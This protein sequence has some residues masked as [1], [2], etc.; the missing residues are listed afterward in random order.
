MKIM[1]L[2][3]GAKTVGVAVSDELLLMAHPVETIK[4]ENENKLRKT[5]ARIEALIKEHDVGKI[6]LGLPLMLDDSVGERAQKTIEFKEKLEKRTGLPVV[7]VDERFTT[8]ASE[9]ELD[10]MDVPR[11]RQKEVI[12]QLAACHILDDYLHNAEK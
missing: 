9:E 5:L 10:Q 8:G 1:G 6:V 12:D 3:Y 7:F 2:D 11:N 4:R